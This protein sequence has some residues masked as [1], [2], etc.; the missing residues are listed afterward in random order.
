[1]MDED[2]DVYYGQIRGF[3]I[4]QYCEKSATITW[5][6]PTKESPLPNV[7]FDPATYIIGPEEDVSRR[8]DCME[9]VMHAPSDYYKAKNT[10]YPLVH[11]SYKPGFIWTS[12][13]PVQRLCNITTITD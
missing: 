13:E 10:P 9:F 12:L 1:M 5:L 8:L 4:D 11:P 6:L 3:L 2:E 7:T